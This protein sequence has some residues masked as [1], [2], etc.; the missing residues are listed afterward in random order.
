MK[1]QVQTVRCLPG[2]VSWVDT[3]ALRAAGYI[4][5]ILPDTPRALTSAF[6]SFGCLFLKMEGLVG[7][8]ALT[9][10]H[11]GLGRPHTQALSVLSCTGIVPAVMF[12]IFG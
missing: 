2:V 5:D 11:P 4:T 3:G 7:K 12:I 8:C 6:L 9:M 1:S 10:P